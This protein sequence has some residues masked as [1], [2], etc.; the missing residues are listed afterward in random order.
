MEITESQIAAWVEE[1]IDN[2]EI[3]LV[4]SIIKGDKGGKRKIIVYLDSDKGLTIDACSSISRQLGSK[5]EE[6]SKLGSFTLEV[7]SYG[8]GRPLKLKHKQ[9]SKHYFDVPYGIH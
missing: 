8:V 9:D 7:S 3:F 4:E 1:I 6:D 2:P 5:L